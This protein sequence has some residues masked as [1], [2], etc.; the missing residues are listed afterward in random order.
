[1]QNGKDVA[2]RKERK[3]FRSI[4]LAAALIA[5]AAF[6][7]TFYTTKTQHVPVAVKAQNGQS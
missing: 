1:M 6:A 4:L 7:M 3:A 5:V 2:P